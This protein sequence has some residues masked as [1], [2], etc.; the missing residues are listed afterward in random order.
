V[1]E[2]NISGCGTIKVI[3][4]QYTL[5]SSALPS[6]TDEID[7][8]LVIIDLCAM[9]GVNVIH[10]GTCT[11]S[12][13]KNEE[14]IKHRPH[15]PHSTH[16]VAKVGGG[17]SMR[18]LLDKLSGTGYQP[19]VVPFYGNFCI[20]A[21]SSTP[22]YD[23]SI[24]NDGH[25]SQFSTD[26]LEYK[27]I[28]ADGSQVAVNAMGIIANHDNKGTRRTGTG[29]DDRILEDDK[30]MIYF[31]RTH[32]GLLGIVYEVTL[33]LYPVQLH[34]VRFIADDISAI[35]EIGALHRDKSGGN[36]TPMID[37]EYLYIY[38]GYEKFIREK[39]YRTDVR[40]TNAGRKKSTLVMNLYQS[41][42]KY[43]DI[44][45]HYFLPVSAVPSFQ[46]GL[47]MLL[48]RWTAFMGHEQLLPYDRGTLAPSH[49][50]ITLADWHF[51]LDNVPKA[52]NA[53]NDL[54]IRFKRDHGVTAS[55]ISVYFIPKNAAGA[56]YTSK[57][58][59]RYAVDMVTYFPANDKI[60]Q[61]EKEWAEIARAFDGL[62][63]FNKNPD[64]NFTAVDI[65][66]I[67]GDLDYERFQNLCHKYDP[68]GIFR[69]PRLNE[70]Y[71]LKKE[72]VQ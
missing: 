29:I 17:A 64:C 71:Q 20:G 50:K 39:H 21:I 3:G 7:K 8:M 38:P 31:L 61:L 45:C 9:T 53:L 63:A 24:A 41:F 1:K 69:N 62:P 44:L 48:V 22:F 43:W 46:H 47:Q 4:G 5:G 28:L 25:H 67:Y 54:C 18:H 57:H 6:C 65:R 55:F 27:M 66:R 37:H 60:V 14:H 13:S 10:A 49:K 2:T 15:S 30:D 33:K 58:D 70:L 52:I 72:K 32:Q 68:Q 16:A 11:R 19:G 35:Q 40:N 12:D 51:T 23:I 26:V 56:G 34:Q 42:F 59:D 36:T